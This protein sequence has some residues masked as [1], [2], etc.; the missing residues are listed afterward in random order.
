MYYICKDKS[1]S[2]TDIISTEYY[3]EYPENGSF[4]KM[5]VHATEYIHKKRNYLI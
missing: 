4:M 5:A 1:L 3:C 2:E